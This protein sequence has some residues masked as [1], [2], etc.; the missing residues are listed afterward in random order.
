MRRLIDNKNADM[1]IV[2]TAIVVMITLALSIVIIWNVVGSIDSSSLDDRLRENALGLQESAGD[3]S[4]DQTWNETTY[5]ANSTDSFTTNLETYFTV[6]PIVLII[7]AAVGILSYL[8]LLK[9]R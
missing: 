2:I 5:V 4:S 1:D 3:N 6:A 9:R 7:I 8:F